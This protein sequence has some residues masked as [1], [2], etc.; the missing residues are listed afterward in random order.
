MTGKPKIR[1]ELE[2]LAKESFK[3][4]ELVHR[5]SIDPL[6]SHHYICRKP[7]TNNYSFN[8]V[9]TPGHVLIYGDIGDATLRCSDSNSKNWLLGA[10]NSIDYVMQKIQQRKDVYYPELA[11]DI[12]K[13]MIAEN[14]CIDEEDTPDTDEEQAT[15][16]WIYENSGDS[17]GCQCCFWYN[18]ND[19]YCYFAIQ[20]FVELY[21][22]KPSQLNEP[23]QVVPLNPN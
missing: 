6:D 9:F 18:T 5:F 2:K 7:G 4:H 20:K 19:L 14:D 13:Q 12:V 8:I 21:Q 17:E 1:E 22:G 16:N 15:L 11:Q 3:D 23:A 10:A